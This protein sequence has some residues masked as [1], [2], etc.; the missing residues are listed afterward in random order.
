MAIVDPQAWLCLNN[1]TLRMNWQSAMGHFRFRP[2]GI[3]HPV[4]PFEPVFPRKGPALRPFPTPNFSLP[5]DAP[6][7][8]NT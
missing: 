8:L 3:P 5:L 7:C 1:V 2:Q 6:L 4:H